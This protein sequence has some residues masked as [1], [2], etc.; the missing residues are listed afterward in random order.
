MLGRQ[1][2]AGIPT[3]IHELF[4]NSHDAYAEHVEVDY[5]RQDSV[6][7]IR[8]DGYGMTRKDLEDRW[9]TL[10]TESRVNANKSADDLE[11]RGPRNPPRRSIMG[12]KG[13][14]R[15]A[16]AVIAPIT[17]LMSKAARPEGIHN[18]V[19]T[20]VHWG[21]F[22]QPGIQIDAIDIPILEI[23]AGRLP[24]NEDICTLVDRVEKNIRALKREITPEAF[25][26]L[27][28]ELEAAK[29]LS[30]D[31]IDLNLNKNRAEPLSLR[32]NGF[33][34]QFIV[35]PVAPE[36]ND[37]IDGGADKEASKLE[38][39][40]LGFSNYMRIEAPV[41]KTEFR[42]HLTYEPTP[43][44]GPNNFFTV[45]EFDPVDHSFDGEFDEYGQ[46]KGI[47]TIFGKP[48]DFVCNWAPGR[49]RLPR[50]GSFKLKFAHVHGQAKES[51]LNSEDWIHIT[52]K[53]DRIGGLYIYRDGIRILP[54]GNSDVDWLDIEKRRTKSASDWFFSFRR[55][56][57]YIS[58]SHAG[59]PSLSEKAGRE[60][61]RENQ[62]Y[63]DFRSILINFFEQLA[64]EFFRKSSPQGEDYLT[65]K[66]ELRIQA[67]LLEK[68]KKKADNR[69]AAFKDELK[70][71]FDRYEKN[72]YEDESSKI[73]GFLKN[74]LTALSALGN[75]SDALLRLRI[76]DTEIW[77]RYRRI[78]NEVVILQPR[79]LALGKAL[80]R[81]WAAYER[82]S[83]TVQEDILNPLQIQIGDT[84][85]LFAQGK[86][87]DAERFE[88]ALLEVE[89][90]RD[91]SIKGLT[92]IRRAALAAAEKMQDTVRFTLKH[93]ISTARSAMEEFIGEFTR[94]AVENPVQFDK[95]RGTV[96]K[97]LVDLYRRE[98]SVIDSFR[99]QMEELAEGIESR[100]T[101]DDRFAALESRNQKLEEQLEFYSE[102]AQMGMA[103]GILQHEFERAAKGIRIALGELKP[104]ADRNPPIY[105]I[106]QP[107]RNHIEHLDGYLKAIDP[108]GRRLHR[109]TVSL[110]GDEILTA[111]R[112][113]F[114]QTLKETKIDVMAT[115]AFRN[116]TLEGKSASLIGAFIN[117]IDNAIYWIDSR[118]SGERKIFLD[119]DN[120]GFLIGNSGPGIEE[121]LRDEI[122][123]FGTTSKPGGRG[124]GLAV[125]REA[126]RRDGFELE[127]RDAGLNVRPIFIIRNK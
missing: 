85:R 29:S 25:D 108:L 23:E 16:I 95:A 22:E 28:N 9:L 32:G 122:F 81:E 118:S 110:S 79:G 99:R 64:L 49:G 121:R 63:R 127:L 46:F 113:V 114:A 7:V 58:I 40:L 33:G 36:L 105:K 84:L 60:G 93:E 80:E 119:A 57:G 19:V 6:L 18:L 41:I 126:L 26:K 31:K 43:L 39:N 48:R 98:H 116:F 30:P 45:E 76:L 12:E 13:I 52:Q 44:I 61:F 47:V 101:L 87:S 2:I 54:Y 1:Q 77:K 5:F 115:D 89:R 17:I 103:V 51:S 34:T 59:N 86:I 35:L 68:Q 4:K 111:V 88:S 107:L 117:V 106:Y 91:N 67:E 42:D 112:R 75:P 65:K 72:Y 124:L 96:E 94:H 92:A 83:K 73:S 74:E 53:L 66:E 27:L 37:D 14:G 70:K 38:R 69:R 109:A 100:E 102:F 123:E 125:S 120:S 78:D 20:L 62:A 15:L 3:A 21:I 50:C 56:F 11:W 8:D 90:E 104:W 24:T 82:M 55:I 10:G 97:N 71:F